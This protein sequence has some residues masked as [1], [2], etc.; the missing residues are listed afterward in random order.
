MTFFITI[1]TISGVKNMFVNSGMAL[2]DL[3][4]VAAFSIV[5]ET[6]A[7]KLLRR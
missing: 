7:E 3:A 2:L 4:L 6:K 5:Y 1:V